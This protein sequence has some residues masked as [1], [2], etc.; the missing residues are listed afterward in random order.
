M[1]RLRWWVRG[2]V[3]LVVGVWGVIVQAAAPKLSRATY[4]RLVA[5]DIAQVQACLSKCLESAAEARRHQPTAR[6]LAMLLAMEA[7]VLGDAALQQQA[8]QLAEALNKKDFA[9]ADKLAKSLKASP[10]ATPLA[11]KPLHKQAGFHLEEVMSPY[12]LGRSGGLNIEKDIRD[13]SKKGA[14]L[15]PAAVEI[16]AARTA[17]LSEYTFH[18][19][20]DKAEINK[21]NTEQ[22]QKYSQDLIELS[23]QLAEE[24]AKGNSANPATMTGLLNKINNKCSDCHNKFRDD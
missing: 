5:V 15:D 9:A 21:A 1:K 2:C 10:S 6:A 3:V 16:L 12:R 22:W 18:M 11:S 7:E 13:W 23:R 14:K 24:A 4:E 8:L 17:L 20:N 19:P